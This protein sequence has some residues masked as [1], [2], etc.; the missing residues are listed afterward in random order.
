MF[1]AVT[2]SLLLCLTIHAS[3]QDTLS[4]AEQLKAIEQEMD[5]LSIFNMIDSLFSMEITPKSELN[6]QFGYSSSVTSAGRDYGLDQAGLSSGIAYYHKSGFYSDLSGYWNA[7]VEPQYN[8]TILSA[9]YLAITP[10][11]WNY[12]FDYEKWFFNPNDSSDNSLTNSLGA[13][14][15]YDFKKGFA[16]IDYS[17]L[18]GEETGHRIISN[19]SWNVKL[20][21]WW[22]FESINLFPSASMMMGNGDITKLRITER[23]SEGQIKNRL[24]K[25]NSFANLDDRNKKNLSILFINANNEGII[26]DSERLQLRQ[27]IRN[28]APLSPTDKQALFK[29]VDSFNQ[30]SELIESNEFGVLNYSFTLPLSLSMQRFNFLLS[31]TYSIPITHPDEFFTVDPVG[32]FGASI[33]YRIPFK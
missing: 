20:G 28:S 27:K 29:V 25:L 16:S 8:P 24:I 2:T 7:G 19:L 9:G 5:S 26:S 18:F 30:T 22:I 12:S 15:N 4:Y 13:S 3:S 14:A 32:Y 1:R 10:S 33:S 6:V 21:K 31:Y 17:F 11:N 23:V